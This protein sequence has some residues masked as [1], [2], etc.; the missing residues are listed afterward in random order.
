[1]WIYSVL[2]LH[3]LEIC[4]GISVTVDWVGNYLLCNLCGNYNSSVHPEIFSCRSMNPCNLYLLLWL[5]NFI[6]ALQFP[7]VAELNLCIWI[8]RSIFKLR[9]WFPRIIRLDRWI[10]HS[11]M[12]I[13]F[14]FICNCNLDM[15]F[16]FPFLD[17]SI[18]EGNCD[19][20]V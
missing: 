17:Q 13:G 7:R 16:I 15:M 4:S 5:P 20:S 10:N 3:S 14:P 11:G 19:C 1:M 12:W 2:W 6:P 18:A 8:P 9:L